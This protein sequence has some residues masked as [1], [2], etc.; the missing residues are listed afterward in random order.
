MSGAYILIL[1][2]PKAQRIK[3]GKLGEI[4]FPR[5]YYFYVGS[6]MKNLRQRVNRHFRKKKKVKWHIDYLTKKFKVIKAKL[7]PSS[8][9][10]ECPIAKILSARLRMVKG[11][12][13][14]DCKCE[15]HLFY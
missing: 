3:V 1:Y 15:S 12:G 2:N 7:F 8:R 13:S 5:G 9:R 14:S 11:F 6:G 4:H 10:L